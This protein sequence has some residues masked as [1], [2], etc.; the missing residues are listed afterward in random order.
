MREREQYWSVINPPRKNVGHD[1]D[2][3][4]NAKS[5]S[6]TSNTTDTYCRAGDTL[7]DRIDQSSD[8]RARKERADSEFDDDAEQRL[9]KR[10]IERQKDKTK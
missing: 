2:A 4:D 10:K 5:T 3:R 6:Q 9:R 8:G 1:D 7:A